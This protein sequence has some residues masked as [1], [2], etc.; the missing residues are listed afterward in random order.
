MAAG[1]FRLGVDLGTSNTV[2]VLAHPDGRVAPLLFDGAPIL[3]SCVCATENGDLV[4]GPDAV[5]AAAGRPASFEP[6]PKRRIDDGTVLLGDVEVPVVDMLAAVLHRVAD[7][8]N[9][10]AGVA[11]QSVTLTHPAGWGAPRQ[12]V[13]RAAA[14]AAG[15]PVPTLVAE[16]VAAAAYFVQVHGDRLPT[17]AALAIFDFGAG[18]FDA[19]VVRREPDGFTTL[20]IEGLDAVG[21]LDID[22]AIV[23]HIGE[24]MTEQEPESWHRLLT[25]PAERRR[26]RAL[27]DDVRAAKEMLSRSSSS[28]VHPPIEG[29]DLPLGR[30]QFDELATPLIAQAVA[31]TD[32]AI[33]AAGRTPAD[34]AGVLFVGGS[35]RIPLA[36][37]LLHRR[38][39]I[40]PTVLDQPEVVVAGGA[41]LA[42]STKPAVIEAIPVPAPP[43][44]REPPR[45]V[46]PAPVRATAKVSRP[47]W[48]VAAIIALAT[49]VPT[50]RTAAGAT[51]FTDG[52]RA[53]L[54]P[55][56]WVAIVGALALLAT[57]GRPR[58][59]GGLAGLAGAAERPRLGWLA[60][61]GA[62]AG[63]GYAFAVAATAVVARWTNHA[64][65]LDAEAFGATVPDARTV[66]RL[67]GAA[68]D[69]L[70]GV[71]V[72]GLAAAALG[73]WLLAG[74]G[75]G[76]GR[77]G[78]TGRGTGV[79]GRPVGRPARL[80]RLAATACAGAVLGIAAQ[81]HAYGLVPDVAAIGGYGDGGSHRPAAIVHL[82][83][84][85]PERDAGFAFA[86][87]VLG[88]GGLPA[89]ALGALFTVGVV[90]VAI[91]VI[92]C[93]ALAR[94]WLS[95]AT[96]PV[97]AYAAGVGYGL[98]AVS[99]LALAYHAWTEITYWSRWHRDGG[100][101]WQPVPRPSLLAAVPTVWLVVAPPLA[102][103]LGIGAVA[104][105][106]KSWR[107]PTQLLIRGP[108]RGE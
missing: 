29:P 1:V 56:G 72:A 21:G 45:S 79:L 98:F 28:V 74:R 88:A 68:G 67:Q 64:R 93:A 85:H 40:A 39:G 59:R 106:V 23:E 89:A 13:L 101:Y 92:L 18:T 53:P 97:R 43:T 54:G 107:S 63:A 55:T 46:V 61:T 30:E 14:A 103:L 65:L 22:A 69:L 3:P 19:S 86:D 99:G 31:A 41:L 20:A 10:V 78:R 81:T 7:E 104:Y 105:L 57:I 75:G 60:G 17:G 12:Q 76:A 87:Q 9:R 4:V 2:A 62:L 44:K 90:I 51:A 37:T 35:S 5:H 38:L 71:I 83:E 100:G 102:I 91:A 47:L 82:A 50:A 48:I 42:T 25:D 95:A 33:R 49:L 8:A 26:N 6:H 77:A 94:R 27:W 16:P 70:I 96:A 15:L 108:G 32:K 73:L 36:A 11:V 24:V 58:A 84:P 52:L 34:L 80:V 66:E